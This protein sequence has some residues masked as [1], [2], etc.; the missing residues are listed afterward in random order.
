MVS[1]ITPVPLSPAEVA[2]RVADKMGRARDSLFSK[3]EYLADPDILNRV[4]WERIGTGHQLVIK[5]VRTVTPSPSAETSALSSDEDD[6]ASPNLPHTP[7]TDTPTSSSDEDDKAS[8]DSTYTPTT[9]TSTLSPREDDDASP[10]P[11][12]I[13]SA[14]TVPPEP[15]TPAVLSIVV[16]LIPGASWLYPDTK[17]TK[18]NKYVPHFQDVKLLCTGG[19]PQHPHFSPDFNPSIDN[20]NTIMGQ[21]GDGRNKRSTITT[22]QPRAQVKIRHPLFTVCFSEYYTG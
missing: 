20:L 12:F 11:T 14:A 2:F 5:P 4:C 7:A 15:S 8:A 16:Q 9:D 6:K 1:T 18:D 3:G 21:L 19:V 17:W 13:P 22:D 10:D